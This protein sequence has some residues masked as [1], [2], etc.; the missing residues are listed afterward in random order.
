[1]SA[2]ANLEKPRF[3]YWGL[4]SRAQMSM[5]MLRSMNIDYVWDTATANTW[6]E[7]KEK[8]PFAQLPVLYH[9]NLTIAQSGTIARYCAKLANIWPTNIE[10]NVMADML[11]QQSED[12][13]KLFAKAKYAG[14]DDQQRTAWLEVKLNKLP[15][16]LNSLVK[17][18]GEKSY[19]SGNN[20]H[21]GDIAVFSTMHLMVQAGLGDMLLQY[22]TLSAHYQ[23]IL[24]QGSVKEFV[25]DDNKAYFKVPEPKVVHSEKELQA[26]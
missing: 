6:P 26:F 7:P 23:K 11:M 5:L 25:K 14:D 12:I 9:N 8:M 4:N 16:K 21:A 10:H 2:L 19:F 18:L 13:F 22:P 3:V 24:Q 17:L 20:F 15:Q 1:M